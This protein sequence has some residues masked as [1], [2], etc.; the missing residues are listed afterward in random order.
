MIPI[1][2]IEP[3]TIQNIFQRFANIQLIDKYHAYEIF[4]SG[5]EVITGDLEIIQSEG[6]EAIKQVDPNMVIKKKNGKE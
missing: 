3:H 2:N 4:H 6:Q 1:R 5:Y